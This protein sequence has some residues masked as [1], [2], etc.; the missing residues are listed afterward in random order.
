MKRFVRNLVL[1]TAVAATTFAAIPVQAQE[2]GNGYRMD[3]QTEKLVGI[4]FLGLAAGVLVGALAAEADGNHRNP[5]PRPHQD[6]N[7]FPDAPSNVGHQGYNNYSDYDQDGPRY[8][9]YERADRYYDE[10]PRYSQRVRPT[11]RVRPYE[12]WS[13]EWARWCQN[14]YQSFNINTGTFTTYGGEQRFCVVQ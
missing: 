1:S 2:G 4:G 6:R 11:E 9:R 3:P 5:K 7:F 12:A 10:G 14:R 13:P 8:R